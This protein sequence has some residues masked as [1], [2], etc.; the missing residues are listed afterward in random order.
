MRKMKRKNYAKGGKVE[1]GHI[2]DP[3][4]AGDEAI[5]HF[6][7]EGP[8]TRQKYNM[9]ARKYKDGDDSQLSKQPKDSNLHGDAREHDEEDEHDAD[10]VSKIRRG[11]K[12]RGY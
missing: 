1:D 5:T 11:M 8:A 10:I 4:D 12:K 9:V 6:A 2:D 7:E 3:F